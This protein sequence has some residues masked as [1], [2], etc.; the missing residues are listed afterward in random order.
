MDG[1]FL[2]HRQTEIARVIALP[3]DGLSWVADHRPKDVAIFEEDDVCMFDGIGDITAKKL[4]YYE[5][6]TTV[7]HILY[8]LDKDT[9]TL[10]KANILS[11][12]I[13]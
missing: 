7:G 12:G 1:D 4:K 13:L 2:V 10:S 11:V 6:V 8:F 5:S 9:K 3:G